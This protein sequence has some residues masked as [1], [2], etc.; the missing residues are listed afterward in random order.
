MIKDGL[1]WDRIIIENNNHQL[2]KRC[3]PAG[4]PLYNRCKT[5]SYEG[6]KIEDCEG[7]KK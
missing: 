7:K 3:L 5:L 6:Y 2:C 4:N 1:D